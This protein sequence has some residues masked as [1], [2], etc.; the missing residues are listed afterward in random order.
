MHKNSFTANV[1]NSTPNTRYMY[2]SAAN[3]F[4]KNHSKLTVTSPS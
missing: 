1:Y 2:N 3:T 4:R